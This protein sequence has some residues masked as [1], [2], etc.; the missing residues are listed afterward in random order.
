MTFEQAMRGLKLWFA[1][2]NLSTDSLTFILNFSDD[3]EA[4]QFDMVLRQA[5]DTR[6]IPYKPTSDLQETTM[7]GLKIR[8]ESPLHAEPK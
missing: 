7:S 3:R 4:W 8:V 2:N 5:I 6:L 1:E